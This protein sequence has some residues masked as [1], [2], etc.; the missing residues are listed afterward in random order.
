MLGVRSR[1]FSPFNRSS[2]VVCVALILRRAAIW[3]W[4]K[5]A[6]F[7]HCLN[8]LGVGTILAPQLGQCVI[9]RA[10]PGFILLS[11]EARIVGRDALNGKPLSPCRRIHRIL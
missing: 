7:R 1:P 11:L 10:W 3:R 4:V 2:L 6:A 8:S 9:V 5:S